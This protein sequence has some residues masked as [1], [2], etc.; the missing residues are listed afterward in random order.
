MRL[1][2]D[3]TYGE[4]SLQDRGRTGYRQHGVS[5]AGPFDRFSAAQA[6]ALVG[7]VGPVVEVGGSLLATCEA[8]GTLAWA[9]SG[10]VTVRGRELRPGRSRVSVG[11]R[12]EAHGAARIYFAT[13]GGWIG[14]VALGSVSGSVEGV[15]E[16]ESCAWME[17]AALAVGPPRAAQEARI[18]ALAPCPT[19][20]EGRVGRQT[21]RAGVRVEASIPVSLGERSS[22]PIAPGCIQLAPSGEMLVIGP[23]G[24]VTGGYPLV[25]WLCPCDLDRVAQWRPGDEVR[26]RVVS[27]AE[28]LV[29]TAEARRTQ[30]ANLAALR[31]AAGP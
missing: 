24:P 17:E 7:D 12:I 6:T 2:V 5:P 3:S 9:G 25:A 4:V 10:A 14:D 18:V 23:D 21:S 29:A 20:V 22:L 31:L 1:R 13:P 19:V 8:Q 28:A 30:A 11:D 27:E 15:L 16:S 26:F